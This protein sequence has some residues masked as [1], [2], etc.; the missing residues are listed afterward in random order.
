MA[1]PFKELTAAEY[2]S[3]PSDSYLDVVGDRIYYIPNITDGIATWGLKLYNVDDPQGSPVV[4]L[5]DTTIETGYRVLMTMELSGTIAGGQ[6]SHLVLDTGSDIQGNRWINAGPSLANLPIGTNVSWT[7]NTQSYGAKTN[8]NYINGFEF[9]GT[10]L[11]FGPPPPGPGFGIAA[12]LPQ[13][14]SSV[15]TETL[16]INVYKNRIYIIDPASN[17]L[18]N[19]EFDPTFYEINNF[20][21]KNE[22]SIL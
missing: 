19:Q 5:S 4:D 22:V 21:V 6:Q 10:Y 9:I 8:G 17:I 11:N 14:G 3:L 20:L 1:Y 7:V 18:L 15:Y 16:N 12:P 13:I 2:V